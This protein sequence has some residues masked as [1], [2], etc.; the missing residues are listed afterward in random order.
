MGK[1]VSKFQ[2]RYRPEILDY[3]ILPS[4]HLQNPNW[5]LCT[6]CPKD[7]PNINRIGGNSLVINSI[8]SEGS[9]SYPYKIRI[10]PHRLGK[11]WLCL[12]LRESI[13][14]NLKFGFSS[15]TW[16][17][18]KLWKGTIRVHS[19]NSCIHIYLS[20]TYLSFS[21]HPAWIEYGYL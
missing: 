3:I 17:A 1:S 4:W 2:S 13:P 12:Q 19:T 10:I 5:Q 20:R 8:Q 21:K 9:H 14:H 6:N 11:L 16:I 15:N 7:G 18:S